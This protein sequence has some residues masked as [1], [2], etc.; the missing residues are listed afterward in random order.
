MQPRADGT[1][2]RHRSISGLGRQTVVDR[3][4]RRRPSGHLAE[5][6]PMWDEHNTR[7]P[8]LSLRLSGVLLLR[9]AERALSA[10]LFQDPPRTTR[11][12]SQGTPQNCT[13][14]RKYG[15]PGVETQKNERRWRCQ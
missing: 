8:I 11:A 4:F 12:R 14:P 6:I 1:H 7:N 10:L 3:H 5:K 9:A 2:L 15:A 13:L